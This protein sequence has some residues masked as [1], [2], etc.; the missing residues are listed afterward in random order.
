MIFMSLSSRFSVLTL[1]YSMTVSL[2]YTACL[3]GAVKLARG[4][5]D[6]KNRGPRRSELVHASAVENWSIALCGLSAAGAWW[7]ILL[8]FLFFFFT[9]TL[10]FTEHGTS[11]VEN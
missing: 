6:K 4:Q 2:S 9:T 5:P 11:A 1:Q 7:L 10:T 8:T 3:S